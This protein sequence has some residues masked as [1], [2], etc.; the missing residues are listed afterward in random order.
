MLRFKAFVSKYSYLIILF[1]F[2]ALYLAVNVRMNVFSYNNFDFGKFDLGNMSQMLWN[3]LQGRLM[4]LTDYFGTNLPRWSMSHVDPI[5]LLF[6]PIFVVFMHPLTLVFSQL[7]LVIFSSFL[8]YFIA[9]I[10]L[11]NKPI[12]LLISLAY[13]LYPALG[14]LNSR[15]GFHGV[16]AAIPFFLGAFLVFEHMYHTH[17]FTKGKLILFWVLLVITM[18]G[19]EQL[20]LYVFTYA[21]FILFSRTRFIKEFKFSKQYILEFLSTTVMKNVIAMWLVSVIWFVLA[22]FVIIPNYAHY[23]IEGFNKFAEQLEIDPEKVRD[24]DLDNYFLSR[25]QSFGD[26]YFEII[27]NILLN[28][29]D[30]VKVV[31]GGDKIENLQMTFEPILYLPVAAPHVLIMAVPDLLINYL[32]TASGV[33]TAEIKNHRISMIIPVLFLGVIFSI[34]LLNDFLN[35]N[36]E[37]KWKYTRVLKYVIP[38]LLVYSSL[39][40]SFKYD[41]PVALWVNEALRK[42]LPSFIAFA[43]T[44]LEIAQ[45]DELKVGDIV[46]LSDLE[47]KD[48]ECAL[49]IINMIPDG[50]SVSGPDYLGAH[51]SLRETYAI[52]PALHSDADYVIV[53]VFSRKILTILDTDTNL[54][55]NVVEDLIKDPN[56]QLDAGCG[57][58]FVFKKVGPHEKEEI[59]PI[60]ARYEYPAKFEFHILAV[61][62]IVD[63]T[64][65][66]SI[67]R[68]DEY[69]LEVVFSRRDDSSVNDYII[70]TT[71]VNIDTGEMYQAANLP[72]FALKTPGE[73]QENYYYVESN[74][75]KLPYFIEEG[76]YRVFVG[77]S[78]NVKTRSVYLGNIKVL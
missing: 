1:V 60:Q 15:T 77:A 73:W 49:K 17:S 76:D 38:V 75:L 69:N 20:P 41:N 21:V 42:R 47:N 63:F 36:L 50:A 70:F 55:R 9:D 66:K 13:L 54:V 52:F 40:Y 4:Y 18:S 35:K 24:V 37:Q 57:N 59:L 14:Y 72:S 67:V 29:N 5:L 16:S 56:Y 46:R 44:D 2:S 62:T 78:N 3:T 8:I 25:Y 58:L 28:P 7:V 32:T 31:F 61:M 6:L 51:L 27:I 64:I 11:K 30:V 33:G 22:F 53:D 12:S 34:K 68:G 10:N 48:R 26:S 19:K 71:F 74:S 45:Q 65:P 39:H 23:R 43:K